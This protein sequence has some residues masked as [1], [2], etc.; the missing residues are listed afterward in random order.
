MGT[1]KKTN[2]I[3]FFL[4][5]TAIQ[6]LLLAA[7]ARNGGFSWL[8][9]LP[10]ALCV[11]LSYLLTVAKSPEDAPACR[12]LV[13]HLFLDCCLL[14]VLRGRFLLQMRDPSLLRQNAVAGGSTAAVLSW[15]V[16][17]VGVLLLFLGMK[18][19][20]RASWVPLGCGVLGAVTVLPR[21]CGG[22][23]K[24][25]RFLPGGEGVVLAFLLFAVLWYVSYQVVLAAAPEKYGELNTQTVLV[26]AV[27]L[28]INLLE[29]GYLRY[30]V[31]PTATAIYE[32]LTTWKCAIPLVVLLCL[33]FA[34]YEEDDKGRCT[35]DSMTSFN[36]AGLLVNL[37]LVLNWAADSLPAWLLFLGAVALWGVCLHRAVAGKQMLRTDAANYLWLQF[38]VFALVLAA[39]IRGLWPTLAVTLAFALLFYAQ[40]DRMRAKPRGN[41]LW[42]SV[43]AFLAAEAAAVRVFRGITA[44]HAAM[45]GAIT[46][47]AALCLLLLNWPHPSGRST[48]SNGLR[49]A[50]CGGAAVL[51]ALVALAH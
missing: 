45:L 29:P 47:A 40:F 14:L 2:K 46:L 51:L 22:L 13:T 42:L 31:S 38:P 28:V 25:L 15:A 32:F 10:L 41:L 3:L 26:Y 50:V 35:P 4:G 18:S 1:S 7:I 20:R 49:A 43:L 17:A 19:P 9:L 33:S 11:F 21:W 6:G 24:T 48:A 12:H 34:M 30:C 36:F 39:V 44:A 5:N 23:P 16:L 37:A 8:M 27:V